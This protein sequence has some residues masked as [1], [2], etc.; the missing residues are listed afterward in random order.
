V[1][2]SSSVP[3]NQKERLPGVTRARQRWEHRQALTAAVT[4]T[5][6]A[7]ELATLLYPAGQTD[8]LSRLEA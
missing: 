3:L 4:A 6:Q 2:A 8:F 7:V 1:W 5:Q